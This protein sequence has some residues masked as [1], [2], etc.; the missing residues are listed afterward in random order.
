MPPTTG[1]ASHALISLCELEL[2]EMD[3]ETFRSRFPN[4][5]SCCGV[6]SSKGIALRDL[7]CT[8]KHPQLLYSRRSNSR[9]THIFRL[10][11]QYSRVSSAAEPPVVKANVGMLGGQYKVV[12][13][14]LVQEPRYSP[15]LSLCGPLSSVPAR[16]GNTLLPRSFGNGGSYVGLLHMLQTRLL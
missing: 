12:L 3:T 2:R 14:S 15:Q 10:Q 4:A 1:P 11:I 7:G 5:C 8:R 6:S 16:V 13:S 9:C